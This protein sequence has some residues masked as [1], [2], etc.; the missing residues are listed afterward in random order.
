MV[1]VFAA[2]DIIATYLLAGTATRLHIH[3]LYVNDI[4]A[5]YLLAGTATHLHIH[6]LYVNVSL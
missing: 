3:Q 4:I 6:Q 1:F 2:N 5:T